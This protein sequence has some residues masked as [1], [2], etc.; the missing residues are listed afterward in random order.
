MVEI[1]HSSLIEKIKIRGKTDGFEPVFSPLF[2]RKDPSLEGY[3]E[4]G[5]YESLEKALKMKPEEVIEEVKRSG[6]RG[7][8]GA[9]FSTG[10]KWSFMPKD[11]KKFL[12][13]NADEGE[14]ATF[15]DRYI[16]S[17]VPHLLLE[18]MMIAGYAIGSK[19]LF[20][21]IRGEYFQEANI[22]EKAVDEAKRY[23]KDKFGLE[24]RIEVMRGAGAY[25]VGEETGLLSSL[26][27]RR[28]HPRPRPPYPA[29]RGCFDC[30]TCVNNVET[31][32]TVPFIIKYGADWFRSMG[33]EKSTGVK[34]FCVSGCVKNP[35]IYE[36]PMG[37]PLKKLIELAGG[38]KCG[39]QVKMVIPGGTST[40]PLTKEEIEKAA[41]DFESISSLGSLL[42]TASLV[43]VCE[44]KSV[45]EVA[46]SIAKFY[47]EE[48]CGQCAPC[49]EG[50]KFIEY[51]LEKIVH[52]KADE[53]DLD[54]LDDISS[55]IPGSSI[56]ALVDAAAL[57]IRKIVRT[58]R[59]ELMECIK[60]G[61]RKQVCI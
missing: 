31:L 52:G 33:K 28:G 15:K 45:A 36:L 1:S 43:V 4:A 9:G 30:P 39:G 55:T 53:S 20:V 42:G 54:V 49:R 10:M 7:R 60:N 11:G 37:Y 61:H 56:C 22:L 18:G 47:A 5:G 38:T 41:L 21:Y 58:F 16:I 14:P 17:L 46:L 50:T 29:Q 57:P 13:C 12:V 44:H 6:L 40:P 32:A 48:S 35:G 19:D 8:G 24:Y 2:L 51:I 26:E 3:L 25:I 23:V 59:E 27:G 34:L